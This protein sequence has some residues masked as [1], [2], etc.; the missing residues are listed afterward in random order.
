MTGPADTSPPRHDRVSGPGGTAGHQRFGRITEP[1][2]ESPAAEPGES[3]TS[4][5]VR[6]DETGTVYRFREADIVTEGL[7]IV[8]PGERVRFLTDPARSASASYVIRLDIPDVEDY[9]RDVR[10]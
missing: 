3:G 10:A 1:G 7:R 6:D 9:Y 2:A 5:A 4:Y 8:H